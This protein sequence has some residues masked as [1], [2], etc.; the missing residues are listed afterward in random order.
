MD[1]P[2]PSLS[3]NGDQLDISNAYDTGIGEW[4]KV[5][6]AYSYGDIPAASNQKAVL[7]K[8]L[9]DAFANG[10]QFISDSDARAQGGA[11]A[12]AHLWDNGANAVDELNAVLQLRKKAIANFSVDNIRTGEPF[13]V[14]EDVFVPL[15]FYHRYQ[16]E[17]AVKLI[18]GLDYNYKV[19]G[20]KAPSV[21]PVSGV[22][23]AQATRAIFSTLSVEHLAIPEA[24]L[25][26]FPPRAFGYWRGRESFKG[27]TGMSFDALS[28]AATAA[29][30]TLELLLHP[31]RAN[32]M[33]QEKTTNQEMAGFSS[34]LAGFDFNIFVK[35]KGTAYQI[36][37]AKT[38]QYTSL[39][40]IIKLAA[41]R[42]ANAQVRAITMSYLNSLEQ[43]LSKSKDSFDQQLAR[44]I[45][46]Y[47]DDPEEYKVTSSPTIPDGSPIG[48]FQCLNIQE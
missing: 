36:E 11:H 21:K 46:S 18:G 6:V 30:L 24:K 39:Q 33:I 9:E 41:D 14:L 3:F 29:D 8:I 19:K 4:D 25:A 44:E 48:S 13:T 32:R 42:R 10:L 43:K 17:A 26:L 28:A 1:Y 34:L 35:P 12:F 16:T 23:Q 20:D 5:T 2:H 45:A 7:S 15:Y 37:V 31:E 40:H 47:K 27:K 22:L 38:I